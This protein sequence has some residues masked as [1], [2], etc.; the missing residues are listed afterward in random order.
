MTF[1]SL[2]L[3]TLLLCYYSHYVHTLF[4]NFGW[5]YDTLTRYHGRIIDR[6]GK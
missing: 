4:D 3:D 2:V 6:K 5:L 1:D